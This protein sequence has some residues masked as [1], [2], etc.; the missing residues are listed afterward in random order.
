MGRRGRPRTFDREQAL[1][2]AHRLFWTAGYEGTTL[3]DLQEAM[4]GITA[5]SFYAAFGSKEQL[6]REV[7][8]LH[9]ATEGVP[10]Q[11]ALEEGATTRESIENMLVASAEMTAQPGKPRGCLLVLGAINCT[12]GNEAVQD[13]LRTMRAKRHKTIR[14]R[15]ERGVAEGEL[16]GKVDLHAIASFYVTVLDGIALQARDGASRKSLIATA[17]SAM[18]A[19]DALVGA[20]AG[21]KARRRA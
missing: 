8:D 4:G 6:F 2:E 11:Q 3:Q 16:S 14:A 5:P 21:R 12:H 13:T 7:A 10:V 9:C 20:A 18:A 1:R 19:W 15:L 17:R